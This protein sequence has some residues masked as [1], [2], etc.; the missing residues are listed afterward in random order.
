MAFLFYIIEY[1]AAT[2]QIISRGKI[3]I[4]TLLVT[5]TALKLDPYLINFHF[6]LAIPDLISMFKIQRKLSRCISSPRV[7]SMD[8]K[9]IVVPYKTRYLLNIVK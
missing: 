6:Y 8:F 9:L 4:L 3:G 2:S 1:Y 7:E 5:P